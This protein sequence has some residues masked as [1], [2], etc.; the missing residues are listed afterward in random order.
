MT[1]KLF[2]TIMCVALLA[3]SV[4]PASA[5]RRYDN[6]RRSTYGRR[7]DDRSVWQKHRDKLTV[8]GGA[9]AGAIVGGLAG[10]KKGAI[11]GALVGAGGS[12]LYTYKLRDR[13]QRRYRRRY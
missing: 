10:G 1:K 11:I 5:Q 2:V 3:V 7:Y 13:D 6:Q 8:A 9:G 12:A 4:V